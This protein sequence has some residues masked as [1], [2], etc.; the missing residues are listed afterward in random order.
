MVRL[1]IRISSVPTEGPCGVCGSPIAPAGGPALFLAE[2]SAAVCRECG[3]RHAPSLAA[4]LYLGRVAERVGRVGRHTLTLP[5]RM[6][7][8]LTHAAEMYAGSA[9]AKKT[10]RAA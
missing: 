1:T 10:P 3:D 7:I 5:I 6:M 2:G 9:G 4:L 8:D